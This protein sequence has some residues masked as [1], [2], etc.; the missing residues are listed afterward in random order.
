MSKEDS[1]AERQGA[2]GESA[3]SRKWRLHNT[4][5]VFIGR[6]VAGK[7][8]HILYLKARTGQLRHHV[9]VREYARAFTLSRTRAVLSRVPAVT[10]RI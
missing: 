5:N 1:Q 9:R 10:G 7:V 8:L 6:R 2:R 4:A 3:G